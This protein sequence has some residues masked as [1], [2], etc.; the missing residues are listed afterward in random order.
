MK[1]I[2]IIWLT[3]LAFI[4]VLVVH[5]QAKD[6]SVMI[7]KENRNAVMITIDQPENITSDALR[8]RLERSGL[9][10]KARNGVTK[11]KGVTLSEIS[12]DK[13]D[14]YTKVE[15]GP[16]NSSVVYMAVSRGY[17]NFTNTL[18]DSNITQNA[19]N[20]LESLV[21]DAD[22]HYADVEISNQINDLNKE[23]KSY[24]Q[25]LNEQNDLQQ[26]KV[27][28]DN[29]L[30]EIQN[31]LILKREGINKMKSGLEDAKGKRISLRQ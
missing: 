9:K 21:K 2:K 3:S 22:N 24:Q 16:N 29:R 11:Y 10:E 28:I 15:K 13:V 7:D 31:E 1:N 18:V 6:A 30:I 25:L 27:N 23:E 17:N 26:K 8:Q 19:K 4:S 5:G 12:R 20:F 14:I